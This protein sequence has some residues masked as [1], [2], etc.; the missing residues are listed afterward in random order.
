[1]QIVTINQKNIFI[2][3]YKASLDKYAQYENTIKDMI[4]SFKFL[5]K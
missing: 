1:L 4:S 3:T 2:I 5:K